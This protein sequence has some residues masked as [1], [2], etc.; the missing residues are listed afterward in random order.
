MPKA[1]DPSQRFR[2]VLSSDV[3]KDPKPTFVY[4]YLTGRQQMAML[5]LYETIDDSAGQRANMEK[6]FELAAMYLLQWENISDPQT[7]EPMEFD[8]HRLADVCSV[9]EAM[10]LAHRVLWGQTLDLMDKKKSD[11]PS[12]SAGAESAKPAPG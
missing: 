9:L 12:A 7:G 1:A 3:D 6:A 10:E 8:R 11:W 5:D 4:P 2:V